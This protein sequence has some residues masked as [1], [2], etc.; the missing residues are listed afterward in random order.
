[1]DVERAEFAFQDGRGGSMTMLRECRGAARPAL[2]ARQLRIG[3]ERSSDAVTDSHAL[4]L[5]GDPGWAQTFQVVEGG[6]ELLVRTVTLSADL[7]AYDWVLV[8]AGEAERDAAFD[9]WWSSFVRVGAPGDA[10]VEA[11]E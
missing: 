3:I 9:L 10:A 4:E 6:R 2:L 8:G 11:S 5:N 7:C 1:M